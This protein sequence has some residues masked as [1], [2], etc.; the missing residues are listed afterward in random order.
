MTKE[1][2]TQLLRMA[3]VIEAAGVLKKL[4]TI[5]IYYNTVT[6]GVTVSRNA[7]VEWL[8]MAKEVQVA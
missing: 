8:R 7:L 2:Q 4:D 3:D 6:D 1:E 5:F